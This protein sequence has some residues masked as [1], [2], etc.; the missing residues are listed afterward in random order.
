MAIAPIQGALR[1]SALLHISLGL[2]SGLVGG[3][4]FWYLHHLRNVRI[5][6]EWYAQQREAQ[7]QA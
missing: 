7:A 6:D 5:R 1:R 3:Y 2:G 4:S